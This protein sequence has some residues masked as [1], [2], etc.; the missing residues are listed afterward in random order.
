MTD[1]ET[2]DNMG[3]NLPC[4]VSGCDFATGEVSECAAV[5]LL[6]NHNLAHQVVRPAGDTAS[7]RM[8][9][10]DRPRVDVGV[11]LEQWN[12]FLR[13]WEVF[14]RGCGID[15]GSAAFQLF[16]CAETDL[17]DSLLRAYPTVTSRPEAEV[18]AAMRSLAV[19]PVATCVQRA[20][21]LGL[22]QERD[23]AFHRP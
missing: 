20:G 5:A 14:R 11:S 17:S 4:S 8:P 10:L 16:Q 13:K 12:I 23:E 9:Q 2:S 19:V 7:H 18:L 15:N 22:R 21:L 6:N 3:I 1:S